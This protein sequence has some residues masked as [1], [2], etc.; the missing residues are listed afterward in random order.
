MTPEENLR[1]GRLDEALADAK[2]AVR[3][4]PADVRLRRFLFQLHCI[5]GNWE[6]ALTQLQVLSD[7]DSESMMLASIFQPVIQCEF[8][9]G[10]VFAGSVRR[11]FSV[12]PSIGWV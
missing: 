2:G 5:L 4:A 3:A 10:E 1:A 7:M 9:R 8:L 11:S 6:K 12:N